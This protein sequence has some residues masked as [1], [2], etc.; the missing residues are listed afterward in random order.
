MRDWKTL[1]ET[2]TLGEQMDVINENAKSSEFIDDMLDKVISNGYIYTGQET[3]GGKFVLPLQNVDLTGVVPSALYFD[4][5]KLFFRNTNKVVELD[6]FPVD[7]LSYANGKPQFL[8]FRD[9]LSYRVSDYMFGQ[10]D[11]VLLARFIINTDSTWNQFYCIP[12]RATSPLYHSGDEFYELDGLF[13]KSPEGLKLSTTQGTVK[14]SG[15]EFSDTVSPD[16]YKSY[17]LET[18]PVPIRY[19]NTSNEIDYTAD[20]IDNI[21]T[22]RYMIYNNNIKLKT[23]AEELIREIINL[24]YGI[25]DFATSKAD[26]LHNAIVLDATLADRQSICKVFTD[27]ID[28]IYEQVQS[29]LTILGDSSLSSVDTTDLSNNITSINT[30]LNSKLKGTAISALVTETQTIAM[31][32]TPSYIIEGDTSICNKPLEDILQDIIDSLNEIVYPVG[33]LQ[34]VPV[35]KFTVQ[36][37]L[38]DVYEDCFICQYGNQIYDDFEDAAEGTGLLDFPAPYGK[39]IYIPTAVMIVKSGITSINDDADTVIITR[40]WVYVDSS[41]DV[42]S[43]VIARARADLALSQIQDIIGGITPAGKADSLKYT[44]NGTTYY[45]DGDY[46]LNY[47]N[48]R[49]KVVVVNNLTSST[50]S[51]LQ[52]LSAYQGYVLQQNKLNRDGTQEMTGTLKAQ[53]IN[54]K[55]TG[56][57]DLGTTSLIWNTAYIKNPH[58][59]GELYRGTGTSTRYIYSGGS[60]SS[61]YDIRAMSKSTYN[62]LS[63]KP[64]GSLYFCW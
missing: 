33:T 43:D 4:N 44:D 26:E 60:A 39:T 31:R 20:P 35:G 48:L 63:D 45:A 38:W 59:T 52:A 16:I 41:F 1:E 24:Y 64:N 29:L 12:S 13:V 3:I 22:N 28:Y 55:T 9:D 5:F 56:T 34:S 49:N 46:Y 54:P 21:I 7:L 6:Q 42:N 58:V 32:Q 51:A 50:Y 10:T 40:R 27:K 37:I 57:Y 8:Y 25:N 30:F 19:V 18:T 23:Q 15:I 36:R 14:R 53:S 61:V 62:S 11:E 17:R 2:N 47:N